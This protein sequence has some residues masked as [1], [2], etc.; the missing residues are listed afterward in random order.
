MYKLG[1]CFPPRGAHPIEPITCLHYGGPGGRGIQCCVAALC[2]HSLHLRHNQSGDSIDS[3]PSVDRPTIKFNLVDPKRNTLQSHKFLLQH[4]EGV[5]HGCGLRGGQMEKEECGEDAGGCV[6]LTDWA[7][8]E[9]T[10]CTCGTKSDFGSRTKLL[11][12]M[13]HWITGMIASNRR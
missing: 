4:F 6:M 12:A 9:V 3:R 2:T 1:N 5:E 13:N 10:R 8:K 7:C 11:R